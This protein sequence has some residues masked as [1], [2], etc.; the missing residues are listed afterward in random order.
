MKGLQRKVW[1][2][3]WDVGLTESGFEIF[4]SEALAIDAALSYADEMSLLTPTTMTERAARRQLAE[5]GSIE[6]DSEQCY[7]GVEEHEVQGCHL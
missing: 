2:A 5:T 6:F 4:A 1:V 3:K 7:Y